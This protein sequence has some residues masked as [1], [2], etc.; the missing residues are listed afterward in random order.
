MRANFTAAQSVSLNVPDAGVPIQHYLRQP[1]RLVYAL[2][3]ARQVEIL[4]EDCYRLKMKPRQFLAL[5]LQPTVDIQIC[6]QPNG[7]LYLRSEDCEI[8]GVDFINSRFQLD[9]QGILVPTQYQGQT[10]L[11]GQADLQVS[12]DVPPMFW[13]TPKP[14]LEA[15]GNGLLRSIL[16]TIKQRLVHQLMLDYQTWASSE[17]GAQGFVQSFSINSQGI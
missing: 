17:E 15:T 13:L 10:V 9:L 1:K 5:K 11:S 4:R 3:D 6:P 7:A 2:A 16:L 12:V 8:R 14:V